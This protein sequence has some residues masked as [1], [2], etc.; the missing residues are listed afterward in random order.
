MELL[1]KLIKYFNILT[2]FLCLWDS[3]ADEPHYSQ[4]EWPIRHKLKPGNHNVK[5]INLVD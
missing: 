4:Q 5:L 3:R 2:V 1:L